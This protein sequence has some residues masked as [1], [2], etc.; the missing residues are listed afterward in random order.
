MPA[1]SLILVRSSPQC[2]GAKVVHHNFNEHKIRVQFAS[3]TKTW[4]EG[5]VYGSVASDHKL[6]E[7]LDKAPTQWVDTRS[8]VPLSDIVARKWQSDGFTRK[9]TMSSYAF[10][11]VCR[12]NSVRTEDETW[13]LATGLE[14]QGGKALLTFLMEND[15]ARFVDKVRKAVEAKETVRRMLL[16]RL[17]FL[18]KAPEKGRCLCPVLGFCY[19]LVKDVL[20]KNGFDGGF[21]AA[22]V[23]TLI[24]GR[25][26]NALCIVGPS[27]MAQSFLL[28]PL[29]LI[30][31]T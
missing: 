14:E 17:V 15:A 7:A 28:K 26:K 13:T 29:V 27:N 1:A 23:G 22:V 25:K 10:I 20:Q 4:A 9:I 19:G 3:Q 18:K 31:K 24:A 2:R 5:I 30:Y 6:P 12:E 8:P 16:T 11:E 21:Q